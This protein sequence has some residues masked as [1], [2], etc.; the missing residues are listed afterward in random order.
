MINTDSTKLLL[1]KTQPTSSDQALIHH[2]FI[3]IEQ[4]H[5]Q[6]LELT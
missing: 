4:A 6:S 3:T 5:W 2:T 1:S